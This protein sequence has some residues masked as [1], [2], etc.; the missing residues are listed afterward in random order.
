MDN[1]F[2]H[3][4]KIM[5]V[6]DEPEIARMLAAILSDEGFT[7]VVT[8]STM[9][10]G[11]RV[12]AA[13]RPDLAILDVMLPDGDGFELLRQLRMLSDVP[14][15]FLTARDDPSGRLSGL[16]LGADDYIAKPFLPQELLLRIYAI[17]RRC[18]KEDAPLLMLDDCLVDFGRAEVIRGDESIP[19]TAMEHTLLETLSRNVGRIVTTDVLC[20]AL[21]GDNP[22]GYANSLNAHVRRVREKIEANP[23]KPT[24]LLTVKGL[25][26]RLVTRR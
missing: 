17:L 9:T 22:Y 21:W 1:S 6:D 10:E 16:G 24:S 26:Y 23:S 4:K 12:A 11:L 18:Y 20:E 15:V 19:L 14:A 7:H 5:V 13:E 8:A 3:A 25:G 2:L